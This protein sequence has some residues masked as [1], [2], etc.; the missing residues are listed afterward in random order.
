VDYRSLFRDPD[1]KEELLDRFDEL[2]PFARPLDGYEGT[3][4]S[5]GLDSGDAVSA[6]TSMQEGTWRRPDEDDGL[7]AIILRFT[8]PVHLV[9]DNTFRRPADR[10]PE[11]EILA[12]R[13]DDARE[14][15]EA[16]IPSVGRVD[17][18]NH[19]LSWL[20]T[21]WLIAPN[22]AVTNRHVAEQF[23][24]AD[25]DG[26]VFR[27]NVL[28][29]EIRA[30]VDWRREFERPH[31]SVFRVTKVLWLAPDETFDIAL[32]ELADTDELGAKLPRPLELAADADICQGAW[33]ATVGYPA[34]DSRND[35]ADQQRIFDGI[36][37]VK[38]LAV[39]TLMS[40][41]PDGL[42]TH[43]ATTL[44]GNSGSAL[45]DLASGKVLALHFGGFFGKHNMAI[46]ASVLSSLVEAHL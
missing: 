18:V 31:E 14:P 28:K 20:G 13:L 12:K 21:S 5:S 7:E 11:S 37:D 44:N 32:L 23:A 46:S 30:K 9:Q 15:L 1:L 8:R 34:L 45:I 2:Q 4:S 39:G 41:V 19:Q 27:K 26:F 25:G 6:I 43:D 3:R 10:F 33:F 42:V 16:A 24:R 22:V 17:V 35:A 38:R 36:Y 40:V 29:R